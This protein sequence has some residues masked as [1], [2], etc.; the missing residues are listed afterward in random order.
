[1]F[2]GKTEPVPPPSTTELPPLAEDVTSLIAR[3]API[4]RTKKHRAPRYERYTTATSAQEYLR[5]GGQRKD[6]KYDI[7]SG[8]IEVTDRGPRVE[9][10]SSDDEPE[11]PNKPRDPNGLASLPAVGEAASMVDM[12]PVQSRT[13][14]AES[15]QRALW[16]FK[17]PNPGRKWENSC[18]TST[19]QYQDTQYD[20]QPKRHDKRRYARL[21]PRESLSP[22]PERSS[23]PEAPNTPASSPRR[24]DE[25]AGPTGEVKRKAEWVGNS[26]DL[27][28]EDSQDDSPPES[29]D[30]TRLSEASRSKG[31]DSTA[32]DEEWDDT[33]PPE[34]PPA[35]VPY[36]PARAAELRV[37]RRRNPSSGRRGATSCSRRVMR[38]TTARTRRTTRRRRSGA[39]R[40]TTGGAAARRRVVCGHGPRRLARPGREG[41][42]ARRRGAR[43]E[44]ARRVGDAGRRGVAAAEPRRE[45]APAMT[46]CLM[47]REHL[48]L[49]SNTGGRGSEVRLAHEAVQVRLLALVELGQV[50]RLERRG[51]LL[52]RRLPGLVVPGVD[53]PQRRAQRRLRPRPLLAREAAPGGADLRADV[54]HGDVDV[55]RLPQVERRRREGGIHSARRAREDGQFH[56]APLLRDRDAADAAARERR[57]RRQVGKVLIH[58]ERRRRGPLQAPSS[59]RSSSPHSDIRRSTVDAH[60]PG[61]GRRRDLRAEPPP[62]IQPSAT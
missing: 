2:G 54:R 34:R 38:P 61:R 12:E 28:L 15:K 57:R 32:V 26:L 62:S 52:R 3:D 59:R 14:D 19:G 33:Q 48:G 5:M 51:R 9:E 45:P 44:H 10:S 1:M 40:P 55:V 46:L 47:L 7:D 27:T 56:D 60:V 29:K 37:R 6:L 49:S 30:E 36:G 21:A 58:A 18:S 23:S 42:D 25:D 4:K 41:A 13:L 17:P 50:G 16:P 31:R 53:L 43:G 20:E 11:Y 8:F 22:V 35:E 39:A 24:E